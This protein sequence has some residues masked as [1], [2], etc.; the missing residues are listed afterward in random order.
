MVT[1]NKGP[2][3]VTF[4]L[5]LSSPKP[6]ILLYVNVLQPAVTVN[7]FVTLK[8]LRQFMSWYDFEAFPKPNPPTLAD[9]FNK[10]VGLRI[11]RKLVPMTGSNQLVLGRLF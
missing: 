6:S 9:R 11:K 2:N 7:N 10:T 5:I 1:P 3:V 4:V 8:V